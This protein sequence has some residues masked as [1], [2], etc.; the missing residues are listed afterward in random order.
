M[1]VFMRHDAWPAVQKAVINYLARA[2]PG[3]ILRVHQAYPSRA[4]QFHHA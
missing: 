2:F 4:H 3:D 1:D